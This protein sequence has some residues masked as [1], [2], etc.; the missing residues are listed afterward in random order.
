MLVSCL[1]L[2]LVYILWIC[3]N[4][5]RGMTQAHALLLGDVLTKLA[6]MM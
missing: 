2:H 6:I 4:T 1:E 5:L 3:I